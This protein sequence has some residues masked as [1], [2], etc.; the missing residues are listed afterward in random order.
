MLF[1]YNILQLTAL[2]LLG[3]LIVVLVLAKEKYRFRIPGR[4]GRGLG[5]LMARLPAGRPR[6]WIHALSVGEVSSARTLVAAIRREMPE[7]V[8]IFSAATSAGEKMAAKILAPDVDLFIPF[9][10]D[11][12]WVTNHFVKTVR[13]D[14]F[15]LVETDFWPNFLA[16]L[17]RRKVPALLVNGRISRKS[18]TKYRAFQPFFR[19]VFN[20]FAALAVQRRED[21]EMLERLGAAGEK[22]VCLGNLKYDA[23]PTGNDPGSGPARADIGIPDDKTVLVAGSTHPGEEEI[24]LDI[25]AA[26]IGDH[27]DLF[28]VIAPRN[29]ERCGEIGRLITGKKLRFCL[30]S[31]RIAAEGSILLLDTMGE[32]AGLYALADLAFVGGSLVHLGGHNPLEPAAS[33][34]PVFFGPH[35]ED[36]ADLTEDLLREKSAFQ[37]ADREELEAGLLGLLEDPAGRRE[38]GRRAA[39]F[40]AARQGVTARHLDLI[41][42]VLS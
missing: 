17:S 39:D 28:L 4:L 19:P 20:S 36:F 26:L 2:L 25:H 38:K 14:L 42:K 7:A 9:P 10:L 13:P 34:I 31:E 18:Y 35:M 22:L 15:V 21:V 24:L 29:I 33:G 12:L 32:L 5:A 16:S 23:V 1:V 3:P 37:V 40:V 27:P 11:I 8:V 30:R 41:K 6:I